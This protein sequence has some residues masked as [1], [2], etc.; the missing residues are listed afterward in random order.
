MTK[1]KGR[2]NGRRRGRGYR[3]GSAETQQHPIFFP[4]T[5]AALGGLECFESF[6]DVTMDKSGDDFPFFEGLRVSLPRSA[7]W[8]VSYSGGTTNKDTTYTSQLGPVSS[9]T[10]HSRIRATVSRKRIVVQG[11][12]KRPVL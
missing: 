3:R 11:A 10:T 9:L 5:A 6:K 8:V 4:T 12:M 7:C 2:H 1:G